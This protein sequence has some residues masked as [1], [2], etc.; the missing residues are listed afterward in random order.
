MILFITCDTDLNFVLHTEMPR[1]DIFDYCPRCGDEETYFT[2]E[3]EYFLFTEHQELLIHMFNLE[4]FPKEK[5][6]LV[7]ENDE[8]WLYENYN[9]LLL[10]Y[11]KP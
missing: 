2:S 5:E 6:I 9:E 4:L 8:A 1:A 7:I 11:E 3:N 10:E